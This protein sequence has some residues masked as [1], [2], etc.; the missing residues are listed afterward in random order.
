VRLPVLDTVHQQQ[1]VTYEPHDMTVKRDKLKYTQLN[2]L[3][4]VQLD[5]LNIEQQ[6]LLTRAHAYGHTV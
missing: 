4:Y 6:D 2:K 3:N 5:I 1:A